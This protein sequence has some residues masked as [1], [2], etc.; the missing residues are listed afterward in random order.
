M[1]EDNGRSRTAWSVS[2]FLE[3]STDQIILSV[4]Q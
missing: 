3:A 1:G 4:S 2:E